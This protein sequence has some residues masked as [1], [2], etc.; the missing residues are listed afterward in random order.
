MRLLSETQMQPV[1][2]VF[3]VLEF[4]LVVYHLPF[5]SKP[6]GYRPLWY[7]LLL[8]LLL[9]FNITNGLFPD[10]ALSLGLRWQY[11]IAYGS[12][13]LM[14]AYVPFYFFKAFGLERLRRYALYG[15]PAIDLGSFL[16]FNVLLYLW[17][18]NILLDSRLAVILPFTYGFWVLAAMYKAIRLQYRESGNRQAYNEQL[19]IFLAILPWQAMAVFAF[20]PCPQGLR[21]VM[22]NLGLVMIMFFLVARLFRSHRKDFSQL[23]EFKQTGGLQSVFKANCEK[24][25]L[26]D[27]EI[28][29]AP[30]LRA[31]YT[32]H[33]IGLALFRSKKTIDND[34]QKL[35]QK[36][37]ATGRLEMI[38][39]LWG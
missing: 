1:T 5:L 37:G 7:V 16:V 31:G 8:T 26:T 17:N 36:V 10:P 38:A 18:G 13:Y 14:G 15:V 32:H 23:F 22:A 28:R 11:I 25:R 20:H 3:I 35:Y 33:K 34:V 27:L 2:M 19:L 39:R 6:K 12:A 21:I 30:L 4:L 9:L 29:L 24:Y